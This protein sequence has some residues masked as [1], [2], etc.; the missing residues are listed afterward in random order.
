MDS[1]LGREIRHSHLKELVDNILIY[2][3]FDHVWFLRFWNS[4]FA[5]L[6]FTIVSS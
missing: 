1:M 3:R 5:R 2:L 4:L 6:E